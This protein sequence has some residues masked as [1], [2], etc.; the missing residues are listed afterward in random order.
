MKRIFLL[1]IMIIIKA[2]F[3]ASDTAFTYINKSK[4]SQESKKNKKAKK[5]KNMIENNH[6]FFGI[7]EVG[8]TMVELLAS[9]YAAEVFM[10]PFSKYLITKGVESNLSILISIIVVTIILSYFLLIFGSVIPKRLARN[11]PEKTAYRLINILSFLAILNTPFEKLVTFSSKIFCKIFRIEER[12]KN[13]LS[14]KEIKMMIL[15]GKDQGIV[16]KIEKDILFNALKFNDITVKKIMRPKEEIDFINV[17]EDINKVLKNI[18]KYKYTRIP[19]FET[20]K[21]HVI[22]ILNV[23]DIALK[24]AEGKDINSD[25]NLKEIV[26]NVMFVQKEEKIPYAFK[27]MQINRQSMMIVLD[28]NEKV[29]GLIT[30]EDIIEKLVGKIFDE[31]DK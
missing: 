4:I 25:F 15:E 12:D 1:I 16:D 24:L 9:A 30:M 19:V 11:N 31:Y 21:D 20:N 14:E 22:G 5:I 29:V 6:R 7:I 28:E 26:R 10:T 13:I 17:K 27:T 8:I 23:K 2:I 18:K 3:S